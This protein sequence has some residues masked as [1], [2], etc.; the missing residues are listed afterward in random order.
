[1]NA[2]VTNTTTVNMQS[3]DPRAVAREI[4]AMLNRQSRAAIQNAAST[5]V[6]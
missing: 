3:D 1:M 6:A 5:V 4:E 2:N